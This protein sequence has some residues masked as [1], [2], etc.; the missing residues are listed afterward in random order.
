MSQRGRKLDRFKSESKGAAK[1]APPCVVPMYGPQ[2]NS[3]WRGVGEMS[4]TGEVGC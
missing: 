2:A 3:L 1:E 4:S